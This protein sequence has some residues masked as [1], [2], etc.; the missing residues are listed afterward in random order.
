LI[1]HYNGTDIEKEYKLK[2]QDIKN[3]YIIITKQLLTLL[4][5]INTKNFFHNDIKLQ[6]VTIKQKKVY[7]IDFGFLSEYSQRG[8]L[9]SMSI[10][11]V[12]KFLH[13]ESYLSKYRQTLQDMYRILESTDIFAFFYFCLDLLGMGKGMYVTYNILDKFQIYGYEQKDL[14]NLFYLYYFILPKDFFNKRI[15]DAVFKY[16]NKK[17]KKYNHILPTVEKAKEIFGDF[18]E[19]HTNLFR[20]MTFIYNNNLDLISIYGMKSENL[21][22]FLKTISDCLLPNFKYD[23]FEPKFTTSVE[24]LFL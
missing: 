14:E 21:I 22:N 18:D 9:M 17:S 1:S 5:K 11:G 16:F 23:E 8:S 10:K 13:E 19:I 15:P 2:I 20:F 24:S 4:K 3:D 6:N 7:L 12:I